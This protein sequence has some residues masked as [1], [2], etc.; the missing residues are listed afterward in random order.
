MSFMLRSPDEVPG[1]PV[2][3]R[4][5]GNTVNGVAAPNAVAENVTVCVPVRGYADIRLDV[6]GS[7][8]IP[9]DLATLSSWTLPRRGGILLASLGEADE[10]G[11]RC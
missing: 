9:G 7:S 2:T 10:I 3:L 6:R 4:F 11:G 8:S 5:Q 1:R